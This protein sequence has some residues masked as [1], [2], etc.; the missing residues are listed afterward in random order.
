[1]GHGMSAD[2]HHKT[3]HYYSKRPRTQTYPRNLGSCCMGK[4]LKRSK[5]GAGTS[6]GRT[7]PSLPWVALHPLGIFSMTGSTLLG[8]TFM[9]V[10]PDYQRQ[11]LGFRLLLRACEEIDSLGWPAFVMA[12]PAGVQLY[13]KFGF[14][15]IGGVETNE[16]VFTSMVRQPR[17]R[18]DG[19]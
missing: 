17:P 6:S 13:T 14:D 3:S 19:L 7:G 16:G 4:R 8:V 18:C 12:S 1:M 10:H 2:C 15:V 11:G 5:K 9:S